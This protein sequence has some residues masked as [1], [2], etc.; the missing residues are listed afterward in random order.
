MIEIRYQDDDGVTHGYEQESS[1]TALGEIDQPEEYPVDAEAPGLALESLA[2]GADNDN[3]NTNAN[4]N[5]HDQDNQGPDPIRSYLRKMSSV[6]L[7]TREGE[8]ELGK[9]IE[10]GQRRILLAILNS[11]VA[12]RQLVELGRAFCQQVTR[13]DSAADET[14]ETPVEPQE[15][16]RTERISQLMDE[17]QRTYQRLLRAESDASSDVEAICERGRREVDIAKR[18]MADALLSL[19]LDPKHLTRIISQLKSLMACIVAARSDIAY[20]EQVSSSGAGVLPNEAAGLAEILDNAQ[21]AIQLIEEE[22]GMPEHVLRDT[23]EEI[24]HGERQAEQAKAEMVKR[25]LRLVIYIAKKY[26]NYSE[27][28]F[29]DLVQEG[30]IG[31]IKAVERY[32]YK[33]GFKFAT[34]A[35][36]WIRQSITF[37]MADQS[38]TIRIP[39]HVVEITNK[40]RRMHRQL[41]QKLGRDVTAEDVAKEMDLSVEKIHEVLNASERTV[42]LD[43]PIGPEGEAHLGDFI[44]DET[45]TS[46]F[47]SLV[48]TSIAKQTRKILATLSPRE[49]EVLRLRFGIDESPARTLEE[50]GKSF[51]LTRERIRQIEAQGLE[52]LRLRSRALGLHTFIE[53]HR[54]DG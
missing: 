44:E 39:A 4:A 2:T 53:G 38:R 14:D 29:M 23:V 49:Q 37:A 30:N 27:L 3:A 52:K 41:V 33:M 46:A 5:D 50:V 26:I 24:R 21:K 28:H 32:D 12:T 10:D 13:V 17:V 51:D 1:T 47:D 35:I 48:S 31:L 20:C 7:L 54:T 16:A 36:W 42:S 15:A 22:L 6:A 9:R 19:R 18:E 8:V 25:N 45:V 43:T 40:V 11:T 34:Y